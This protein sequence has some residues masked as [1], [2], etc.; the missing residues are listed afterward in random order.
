MR[1]LTPLGVFEGDQSGIGKLLFAGIDD[2]QGDRVVPPGDSPPRPTGSSVTKSLMTTSMARRAVRRTRAS[3][4]LSLVLGELVGV[5][6]RARTN[7]ERWRTP[8]AGF[9]LELDPIADQDQ[10]GAVAVLNG[11]RRQECGGLR[12]SVG[13]G[14]PFGPEAHAR[15]DVDHQPERQRPL[16]DESPHE[17]PALPRGHVPVEVA[18]VVARLVGAQLGERQ[19]DSR[20]GAMI[21]PGELRYRPRTNPEPSR[22]AR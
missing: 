18:H 1:D 17:W 2:P 19:A 5:A 8:P 13:L 11:G 10:A 15:R 12:G 16:L 9:E 6:T 14:G 3:P 22:R 4:T 7:C 21:S 20:P